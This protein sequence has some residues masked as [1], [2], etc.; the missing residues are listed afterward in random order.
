MVGA[1]VGRQV[2]DCP[3]V[4]YVKLKVGMTLL[5]TGAVKDIALKGAN[6]VVKLMVLERVHPAAHVNISDSDVETSSVQLKLALDTDSDSEVCCKITPELT[7]T[8]ST[9]K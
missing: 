3:S 1:V 2:G 7:F 5:A 8:L 4:L 9:A 6:R